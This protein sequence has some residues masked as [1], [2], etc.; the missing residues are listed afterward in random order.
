MLGSKIEPVQDEDGR[1]IRFSVEVEMGKENIDPLAV[2]LFGG[3]P[4]DHGPSAVTMRSLR[5]ASR[6]QSLAVLVFLALAACGGGGGGSAPPVAP[7]PP[8]IAQVTPGDRVLNVAFTPSSITGGAPITQYTVSCRAGLEEPVSASGSGSPIVVAGLVNGREYSCSV[9]ARNIAGESARSASV[10]ATPYTTPAAPTIGSV[11]PLDG[12]L[13]AT[14]SPSTDN[15]G[16]T[17]LDYKLSCTA[18]GSVRSVTG[19]SSPLRLAG[20]SNGTSYSCSVTAR[21]AAGDGAAS[22]SKVVTP[23]T[24]PGAPTVSSVIVDVDSLVV[25]F[26]PP[27]SDGGAPISR[28]VAQCGGGNVTRIAAVAASPAVVAGLVNGVTYS[29]TVRATNAAGDGPDSVSSSGT[30]RDLALDAQLSTSVD[31]ATRRATLTWR[32]TFP[33]GTTYRIEAQP[34]GGSFTARAIVSGSGGAGS[35]LNWTT[36]LSEPLTLRVVAVREGRTEVLLKTTQALTTVFVAVVS[37]T[38]PPAILLGSAEPVSGV[39][40]LSVGGGVTYPLVEW[41]INLNRIGVTTQSAGPGN[42]ISWNTSILSNGEYLVVARIQTATNTFT[43]LR[44]TVRVANV[45]LT[46]GTQTFGSTG[47]A[48][49]GFFLIAR[50]SSSAG[51]SSV[52]A[53]IDGNSLGS[54]ATPNCPECFNPI[55]SYRWRIDTVR[56]PSGS[57]PVVVTAIARDGTRKSVDFTLQVNNPPVVTGLTPDDYDIVSGRLTVRGTVATDRQG[58]VR[59]TATLGSLTV[60]ESTAANFE[61]S[62]D[63]GGLPGGNYKLTVRSVDS[64]G[65]STNIIRNIIVTTSEQRKYSPLLALGDDVTLIESDGLQVLSV[66]GDRQYRLW[67]LAGGAPV[68]LIGA[69]AINNL[70]GWKIDS[71]RVVA[72]GRG[73]DCSTVC[74]YEWDTSGLRRNLSA[75]NPYSLVG[76]TR[77]S[78]QDPISRGNFVMWAN[79]LCGKGTYTIFNRGTGS[80]QKIDPPSG[81]NYIG[82]NQFDLLP[83]GS[84]AFIWAQMGGSGTSSTFDVFRTVGGSSSRL[85][86]PGLRSV[87]PRANV[88]RVIWEQSPIGGNSDNTVDLVSA[89][90]TGASSRL[91]ATRVGQWVLTEQIVTWVEITG[92]GSPTARTLRVESGSNIGTISSQAGVMLL[93]A[94]GAQVMYAEDNRFYRWDANQGTR[95]LLLEVVPMQVWASRGVVVFMLGGGKVYRVP[96]P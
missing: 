91:L 23:R 89:S 76:G 41:F 50:A 62:L 7:S 44:R 8:L 63:L 78:D 37:Q 55:D 80:Y 58:G 11:I 57:Y 87:Y 40:T 15:G 74:I 35:A 56:Y 59:T 39:V 52:E 20:L 60:F 61:G 69:D 86:T 22:S 21:N 10:S 16:N 42:P 9:T 19:A 47:L 75:A 27:A 13:E 90:V 36:E 79:W 54:L 77:C 82:N 4:A 1:V 31:Q 14:F 24:L 64:A 93:G 25:V 18:S 45:N 5:R 30:P 17:V 53:R 68:I 49:A 51:I 83:D 81:S 2:L 88:T 26:S 33:S 71:G 3:R 70:T 92:T 34:G 38:D 67:P 96:A 73:S 32:D 72:Q 95:T 46:V 84:A 66:G 65:V 29:C 28:Y 6:F 43:E 48:G 94:T 85:S 12:A